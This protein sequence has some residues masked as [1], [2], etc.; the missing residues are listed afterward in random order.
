ME[1]VSFQLK[2]DELQRKEREFLAQS[3][4]KDERIQRFLAT[5]KVDYEFVLQNAYTLKDYVA[6][7]DQCRD[8]VGLSH[9]KQPNTGYLL[10]VSA[11]DGILDYEYVA[12]RYESKIERQTAHQNKLIY[13]DMSIEQMGYRFTNIDIANESGPYL[14]VAN[15]VERRS[16]ISD[17]QG[18]YLSGLPGVGKTY[19]MCCFINEMATR[20]KRCAFVHVPTLIANL[21]TLMNTPHGYGH[22]IE[23]LKKVEVL[24]LDDIAGESASSWSRD[25]ILLPILNERMEAHR[26]TIF[27]SNCAMDKLEEFYSLGKK[28]VNNELG[29]LRISERIKMLAE[30]K[31]VK[32]KNRR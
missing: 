32:G 28:S 1:K 7:L 13:N 15:Y 26:L 6:R 20:G 10:E 18:F 29:A 22:V 8:C 17:P 11:N 5:Y 3:L 4:I 2:E 14:A 27:T 31:V 9:C 12:C 21:K 30:E 16:T 25:D 24:A 23:K 19:L